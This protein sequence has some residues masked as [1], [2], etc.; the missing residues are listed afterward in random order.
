MEKVRFGFSISTFLVL[1]LIFLQIVNAQ[2]VIKKDLLEIL[3]KTLPEENISVIISFHKKPSLANISTLEA[4][5]VRIKYKYKIINAVAAKLPAKVVE[6]ISNYTFLKSIE[7]DYKVEAVL[8]ESV[9]QIYADKVWEFNITGKDVDV[10][11]L[12]TGIHDEHP[13]LTVIKEIDFTGE[14]TDD[15][16]GHG[17]HVAGIVAS[18]DLT[19][20]GVSFDANLMN[21]KV[22]NQ[23]GY[24]YASDVI[25]GIEWSIDNNA[26]ILSLSLG[27]RVD[28]CDGTDILSRAVDKA[29][30]MGTVVVVAA[31]NFGPE[32]GTIASPGCCRKCITVGAVDKLDRVPFWSSRG[33]TDDGRVKPDLVAP[34]VEITSTFKD[35]TFT[36][37][38]GTSMSTPHVSGVVAL[39]LQKNS[40]L[41]PSEILEILKN[42][43]DDLG[44]D[45]NTQGAG[46][47]NAY[48]A[49][50]RVANITEEPELPQPRVLCDHP[51][52]GLKKTMERMM[53]FFAF[54]P[55]TKAEKHVQ[56]A[57]M[58]LAEAKIMA[59]KRDFRCLPELIEEYETHMNKSE[60][61]SSIAKQLGRNVTKVDEL[62]A[63]ATSIH[64]EVLENVQEKVPEAAKPAIERAINVSIRGQEKALE[65]LSEVLPEKS[66][67]FYFKLAEKRLLKARRRAREKP[68]EV[69]ELIEEYEEKINK[70]REMIEKAKE[71]GRNVTNITET[72]T[73]ATSKHLEVLEEVK[74]RVPEEAKPA[75]EKAMNTSVKGQEEA[76][77]VLREIE[78]KRAEKVERKI[79]ER[80]R[81]I[82]KEIGRPG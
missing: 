44:Y 17:T 18:T 60:E 78:P 15:L 80:V 13:A 11:I 64:I 42:T 23:H 51:L 2:A 45:E 36:E 76:L 20:T 35:N 68:E 28:R 22:L 46:R 79:G 70:T 81:E 33:P 54:D 66:A 24:G 1:I 41:L 56:L 63:V 25:A 7:P 55:V 26:E 21:V 58:R 39:L 53:L 38:S 37:M 59:E 69:S 34:G 65:R 73:I 82:K 6:K 77:K 19:Y 71:I 12:D 14:G 32:R 62:V 40:N 3:N 43:S 31:G 8:D 61:I 50:L 29:V 16:H 30:S 5:G 10:A 4:H 75:I 57:K 67:E 49:F 72:V 52:Y 9:P 48:M 47:I 27:A 74:E